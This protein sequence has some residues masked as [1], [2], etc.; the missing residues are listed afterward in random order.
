MKLMDSVRGLNPDK[1]ITRGHRGYRERG[2]RHGVEHSYDFTDCVVANRDRCLLVVRI[3]HH[4]GRVNVGEHDLIG[5]EHD[6]D[7]SDV[8]V[9]YLYV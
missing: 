7:G 6:I 1:T 3:R 8:G 2:I 4:I 9:Q 5:S